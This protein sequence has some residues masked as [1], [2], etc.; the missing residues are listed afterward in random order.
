MGKGEA[1][2]VAEDEERVRALCRRVLELLG[3][4]V[5]VA[6][7]GLEALEICQSGEKIDLLLTDIVMP[8]MGGQELIRE[9]RRMSFHLKIVVMTG[10]GV[11]EELRHLEEQGS[12]EV[13]HKPL[14]K[15]SLAQV[16]RYALDEGLPPLPDESSAGGGSRHQDEAGDISVAGELV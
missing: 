14:D 13:V 9:L 8:E 5:L 15:N 3:Y 16:V 4:Q 7:N 10:G 12:V 2:L 6:A 1:I 11:S